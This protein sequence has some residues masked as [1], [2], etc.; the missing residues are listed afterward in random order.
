MNGKK[1][2][3]ALVGKSTT[4]GGAN[5]LRPTSTGNHHDPSSKIWKLHG[6]VRKRI[7]V[8]AA[9]RSAARFLASWILEFFH[10]HSADQHGDM[11]VDQGV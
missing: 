7:G 3:A 9:R 5:S 2:V 11:P 4:D 8:S 1:D 6:R 10:R